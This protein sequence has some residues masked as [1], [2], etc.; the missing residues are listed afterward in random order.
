MT[1][2]RGINIRKPDDLHVHLRDGGLLKRVLP[3][4]AKVFG[5]ALVM[6]NLKPAILTAADA[7]SYRLRILR[8]LLDQGIDGFQ[9]LMTIKITG[10]T[11]PFI[12]QEAKSHAVLA[13]KVY[14]EGVTT[15]SD[16][17]VSDFRANLLYEVFGAME[18]IGMILCVHAEFPGGPSMLREATFVDHHVAVWAKAFPN[19]K[20]V[21]EHASTARAIDFA[22]NT[23]NVA[24]SI[25]V[26]HMLLTLDDIIGG[27]LNAHNFCK[28]VAKTHLDRKML[29]FVATSGDPSFFLGTDSAPHYLSDKH[30]GAAGCYT[31]P[32]AMQLLAQIFDEH[33]ALDKLEAFASENGARFYGLPLNEGML[34]LVRKTWTP[35]PGP[36]EDVYPGSIIPFWAGKEIQWQIK[37]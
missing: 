36:D 6:P 35:G 26:H 34:T 14:P 19:L 17:G 15:N 7:V 21:I 5:R 29:R 31:A 27:S 1:T 33:S 8:E 22:L 4:T 32:V 10:R 18:E 23:N 37:D 9:A 13:A 25:T 11:T 12:I 28:P 2:M 30:A 24:C 3:S 16:D 20:I